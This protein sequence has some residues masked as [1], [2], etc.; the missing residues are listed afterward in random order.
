LTAIVAKRSHDEIRDKLREAPCEFVIADVGKAL[1]WIPLD[2]C[3]AFWKT[4]V[5]RHLAPDPLR[6]PLSAFPGE[7][8]YVACEWKTRENC[9]ILLERHH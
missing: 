3:Y 1:D 8:C 2:R 4:E 9:I 5:R 6:M 7:Y